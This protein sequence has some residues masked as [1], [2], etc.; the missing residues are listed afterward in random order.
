VFCFS[1][2][3]LPFLFLLVAS[4]V[5]HFPSC[6]RLWIRNI[7]RCFCFYF[8]SCWAMEGR[9]C[10]SETFVG[11]SSAFYSVCTLKLPL[12]IHIC[13][14]IP[15]HLA[16]FGSLLLSPSSFAASL[17][18][19]LISYSCMLNASMDWWRGCHC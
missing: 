10:H 5:F 3:F 1:A 13:L 8:P 15:N 19:Q 6:W 4:S 7:R 16:Q 2:A 11:A 12:E 17:F 18:H 9:I 14:R